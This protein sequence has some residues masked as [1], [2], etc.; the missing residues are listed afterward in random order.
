MAYEYENRQMK[1][2]GKR[3]HKLLGG[4]AILMLLAIAFA[5]AAGTQIL[6]WFYAVDVNDF[7]FELCVLMLGGGFSAAVYLLYNVLTCMRKQGCILLGYGMATV[8]IMISAL[9]LFRP[10]GILGETLA[11]LGTEIIL[12]TFMY[13]SSIYF[14]RQGRKV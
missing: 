2:L 4:I 10:L 13:C 5:Y 3:I 8:I 1:S 7:R 12:T 6:S 14:I 11:Y 9:L